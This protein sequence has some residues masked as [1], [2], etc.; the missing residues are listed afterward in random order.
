MYYAAIRLGV[1]LKPR[2][3]RLNAKYFDAIDTEMR[4]MGV[5]TYD[6]GVVWDHNSWAWALYALGE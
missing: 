4:H 2:I 6:L 3:P 1:K 5:H